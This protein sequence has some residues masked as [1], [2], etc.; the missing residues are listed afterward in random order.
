MEASMHGQMMDRPLL[1]S[2]LIEHAAR[3]HGDAEIVSRTHDHPL[4][5]TTYAEVHE[6]ARK[7]AG[8]LERLGVAPGDRVATLAWNDFRHVELYFAVSGMGAVC[9]TLNPRLFPEQLVYIVNHAEDA[10]IAVD[11]TFVPLVESFADRIPGVRG[12]L[13]LSDAAHMPATALAGALCYE[14]LLA[15]ETAEREWPVFDERTAS[16]LC[17]TSGT[18][19]HPKGVL[20]SHRSTVLHTF[21]VCMADTLAIG[22]RDVVL[23]VVPM[24]HANAWGLPYATAMCGAKLVMPGPKLDGESVCELLGGEGVTF[25]AGVPTVWLMLLDYLK[26]SGR[27]LPKLERVVIGGA[28]APRSMIAAFERDHGVTVIHSWGMTETSPLGTVGT[29]KRRHR[30]LPE[31]QRLDYQV[32]QGRAIYGV[33][34]K[35]VDDQGRELPRDGKAFGEL[36]VRGPWTVGSYFKGEGGEILEGG[37]FPTGDVATLDRDGYMQITDR[38]KDVIKSGGE[39]ISSIDL[40]NEVLGHP[41]VAEAAVVGVAHPKWSERPLLV[42]V[43][44]DGA[45]P[46]REEILE[47]LRPRV[48]RWWLPDD[49]VFVDE[50]PHTATGKIS[51]KTLRDRFKDHVLPTVA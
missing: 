7:L 51:K 19:G 48:A 1:I 43:P 13:V 46:G 12:F 17:Y 23:P 49:V 24:F 35:V 26:K 28:A 37:W 34:L 40:E 22:S 3:Y 39:W 18:T 20:F 42:V 16:S 31:E 14:T 33:E 30:E 4:H 15:A 27:R 50:L 6:R 5:R 25:T 10:W 38:S 11:P 32:K 29:L 2:S 47:Y 44:A 36:M 9:H 41:G 45:R 21:G 8:A